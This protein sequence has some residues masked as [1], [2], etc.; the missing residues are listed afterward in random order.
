MGGLSI[1]AA[2][3][4]KDIIEYTRDRLYVMLSV[5]SL[6]V[7]V[8]IFWVLPATVDET[9]V[10]GI[11]Q[12]GM[13]ELLSA[14]EAEEGTGIR[15]VEF[16]T[17][18]DLQA[19]V[20]GQSGTERVSLGM[21]FPESFLVDI[22]AGRESSVTLY[23]DGAVPEETRAAMQ[24]FIREI[25][26]TLAG[27]D[28][29]VTQPAQDTVV[30]GEDRAGDQVPLREKMK[31]L[32]AF[33]VLL[34]ESFALASLISTEIQERTVTAILVTPARVRELLVAK[35]VFGTLLAFSQAIVL[36]LAVRAF[37]GSPLALVLA[38]L[39]GAV[40]MTGVGMISGSAGRDFLG[41]LFYG[42]LFM[43]PL[44][45]PAFAALYPGVASF[46]VRLIPSH[47]LVQAI[48]AAGPTGGGWSEAAPYLLMS[49]GW[50][51]VLFAVG[52]VVLKRKVEAL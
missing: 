34:V 14:V 31:P 19:A 36:L 5:L 48:S 26:Y 29:P 50:C 47:G 16:A 13:E 21:S 22:S 17:S 42:M 30:L 28:L 38:V 35:G 3:V 11:R 52:V 46:W 6:I 12:T 10:V 43:I 9:L 44:A 8:A 2:I 20:S 4:R 18:E 33:F 51:V 1:V 39:L 41:T 7:F 25:A 15:F 24:S 32:F 49:L 45:I 37:V 40:M 23:V 27:H